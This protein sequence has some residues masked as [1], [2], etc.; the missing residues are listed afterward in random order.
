MCNYATY[1]QNCLNKH[2]TVHTGEK[3]FQCDHCDYRCSIKS[4]LRMH[5]KTH[6]AQEKHYKCKVC[7]YSAHQNSHL[8]RHNRWHTG[9]KPDKCEHCDYA[10]A[11]KHNLTEH[12]TSKHSLCT[13]DGP[14]SG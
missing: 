8:K 6:T 4:N 11:Q 13:N 7:C 2:M 9:E 12:I 10:A 14:S 5:M 3:P 1:S